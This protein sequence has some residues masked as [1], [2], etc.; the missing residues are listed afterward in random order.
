V[1][2]VSSD[3]LSDLGIKW[4]ESFGVSTP[5][6]VTTYGALKDLTRN[7]LVVT[8]LSVGLNLM[9]Q[10][11]DTNILASPRIRTRH[12]E[13][14]KVLVGDKVPVITNLLTPQ[15]AGQTS[16]ITGSIQYVDVGIKL[17]VEPQVYADGDV[18]IK[19]NL[20]VSSI[21]KTITTQS[22]VA[23]QIGTRSAQTSL[24]LHD[25]ETQVLAG[26]ISDQDRNTAS[27]VPA[28]GQAPVLGRLFSS[29][30]GSTSKSEVV[31]SITPRVIRPQTVPEHRVA[32]LWTGTEASV[33]D[34]PLRLDPIS[35]ARTGSLAEVDAARRASPANAAPPAGPGGAGAGGEAPAD[36]AARQGA[37]TAPKAGGAGGSSILNASRPAMAGAGGGAPGEPATGT[38]T[39][40]GA[41][42]G[43]AAGA[44][45]PASSAGSPATA[46]APGTSSGGRA[47]QR[48]PAPPSVQPGRAM[49][50]AAPSAPPGTPTPPAGG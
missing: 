12:K 32:E 36:A 13:K 43:S 34:R 40:A 42:A 23:Y 38:G 29:N 28:L 26:L 4:P 37:A 21:G 17:E 41:G 44:A 27:K 46:D 18:G 45:A 47:N 3:R 8:P 2:E 5:S 14:A 7:D 6:G 22:G 15:Q 11:T 9:L 50:P 49:V 1:L 20:E 10:D 16:V 30:N 31:L 25:G 19:L 48:K 39:A 35:A 33:R 24:R